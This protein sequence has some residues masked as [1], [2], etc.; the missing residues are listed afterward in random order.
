MPRIDGQQGGLRRAQA[1][2]V[3]DVATRVSTER[4]HGIDSRLG[5]RQRGCRD[6]VRLSA[7]HSQRAAGQDVLLSY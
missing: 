6:G 7:M 3:P 5:R 1:E 4:V 2:S